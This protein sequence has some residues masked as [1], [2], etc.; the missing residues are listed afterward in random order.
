MKPGEQVTGVRVVVGYYTGKIR[1]QIRV[2][3]G[4]IPEQAVFYIHALTVEDARKLRDSEGDI[5]PDFWLNRMKRATVD[6]RR[7]FVFE[8][9]PPGEYEVTLNYYPS[10]PL[11]IDVARRGI[12]VTR[13]VVV[14]NGSET[15]LALT[16]DLSVK[17]EEK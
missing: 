15:E 10:S 12:T 4:L 11:N 14:T 17:R 5:G 16:L 1:G 2:E 9:M 13:N 7:I 6:A 8:C 3:G